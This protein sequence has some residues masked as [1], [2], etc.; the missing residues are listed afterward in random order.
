MAELAADPFRGDQDIDHAEPQ[1]GLCPGDGIDA[2]H[3]EALP[4]HRPR[5]LRL[6]SRIVVENQDLHHPCSI[7]DRA[8]SA[9]MGDG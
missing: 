4:H 1:E 5:K 6:E 3:V 7:L 2:E 9:A 8:D